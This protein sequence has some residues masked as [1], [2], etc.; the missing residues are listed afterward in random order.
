MPAG[1]FC[2]DQNTNHVSRIAIDHEE[3]VLWKG[4][5]RKLNCESKHGPAVRSAGAVV[6][7]ELDAG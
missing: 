6:G 4:L 7:L 1:R 3:E 5:I 2:F